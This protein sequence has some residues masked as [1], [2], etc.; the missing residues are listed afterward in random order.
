MIRSWFFPCCQPSPACFKFYLDRAARGNPGSMAICGTYIDG[1]AG[2]IQMFCKLVGIVDSN[3]AE[4]PALGT[5]WGSLENPFQI[6]WLLRAI[7][8]MLF[9]WSSYWEGSFEVSLYLNEIRF[10]LASILVNFIHI[11]REANEVVDSL[12]KELIEMGCVFVLNVF[13]YFE[14]PTFHYVTMLPFWDQQFVLFVLFIYYIFFMIFLY[15]L[16]CIKIISCYW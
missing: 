16:F 11:N 8:P 5:F 2:V 10:K 6:I 13:W 1:E 9:F 3:E 15:M 12:G 7:H 4:I 14:I